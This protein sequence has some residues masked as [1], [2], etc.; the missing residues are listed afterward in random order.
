MIMSDAAPGGKS[1][2]IYAEDNLN[3][4]IWTDFGQQVVVDGG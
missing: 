4:G 1:L 3:N 2:S